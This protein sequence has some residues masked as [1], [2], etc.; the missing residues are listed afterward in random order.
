M[1][2]KLDIVWAPWRLSYIT[3][4]LEKTK[5]QPAKEPQIQVLD[6]GDSQC[7]IC[8]AV[9]DSK[10]PERFAVGQSKNTIAILNRYPYNNGHLLIAPKTHCGTLTELS[11]EIRAELMEQINDW[12]LLLEDVLHP[13]GFNVGLNLG[14]VAGAG[15]PGHLHW[16]IVPRWNGDVNFMTT[17]SDSKVIPQSLAALAEILHARTA[18]KQ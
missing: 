17:I 18:A 7:F 12:I 6:G 3:A 2:N 11:P 13:E 16:H 10:Q 5:F 9:V 15:L 14:H 1:T 4:D 8:Q